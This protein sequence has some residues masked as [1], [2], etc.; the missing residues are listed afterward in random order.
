[1]VSWQERYP[2][3]ARRRNQLLRKIHK[4]REEWDKLWDLL[5]LL[6]YP[7]KS[8]WGWEEGTTAFQ[9]LTSSQ[10]ELKKKCQEECRKQL[11]RASL[12]PNPVLQAPLPPKYQIPDKWKSEK[13]KASYPAQ[14]A[15]RQSSHLD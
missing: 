15:K 7:G 9:F 1:M 11:R 12:P 14:G 6:Q 10:E 2:F 3:L 4:T 8:R 13:R 5:L